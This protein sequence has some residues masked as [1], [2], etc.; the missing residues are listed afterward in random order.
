MNKN[1]SKTVLLSTYESVAG[2]VL[3]CNWTQCLNSSAGFVLYFFLTMTVANVAIISS[4]SL[5]LSSSLSDAKFKIKSAA[6]AI[7][8]VHILF[9]T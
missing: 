5:L 8:N 6:N 1:K 3:H 7:D 2:I 9:Y 4:S